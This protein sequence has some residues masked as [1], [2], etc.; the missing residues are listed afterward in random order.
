MCLLALGGAVAGITVA[1]AGSSHP[2]ALPPPIIGGAV[3]SDRAYW[4]IAYIDDARAHGDVQ[5]TGTVIGPMWVLTAGHCGVEPGTGRP[6]APT[7]FTVYTELAHA[8]PA[9]YEATHVV[10]IVVYPGYGKDILGP[11]AALLRLAHKVRATAVGLDSVGNNHSAGTPAV[12]VGWDTNIGEAKLPSRVEIAPTVVQ[13]DGWCRQKALLF[14]AG[15]D[16][17]TIEPSHYATGFCSGD[18]GG[19]LLLPVSPSP[20]EI[21]IASRAM[22]HCSTKSPAVFTRIAAIRRWADRVTGR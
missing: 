16:I 22:R 1:A 15:A 3:T 12:I 18:S 9:R 6:D 19:P 4:S 13:G 2:R 5:C 8:T 20:I 21:G 17:C 11:D 14:S 10:R 7:D